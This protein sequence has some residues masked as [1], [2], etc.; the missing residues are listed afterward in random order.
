LTEGI[1]QEKVK[2]MKII[3]VGCGRFGS[4]LANRL[5]K[6]GHDIIV[7]DNFPGAFHNLPEGFRG[8]TVEGDALHQDVLHRA[9]IKSAEALAVVTNSDILNATVAHIAQAVFGLK[10]VVVRNYDPACRSIFEVFNTQVISSTS[11]GVQ[12]LIDLVC[13]PEIKAVMTTGNGEVDIYEI[14]V[15][16]EWEDR[17]IR[18]LLQSSECLIVSLTRAG[19]ANLPALDTRLYEGDILHISATMSGIQAVRKR[20]AATREG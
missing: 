16:G 4:E 5:C 13:Q 18:D 14:R 2:S 17:T 3:I 8:R 7:I 20:L 12:R 9:G 10:K 15:P 19:Q 6:I 1:Q 11:W